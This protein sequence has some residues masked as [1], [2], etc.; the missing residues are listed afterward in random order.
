MGLTSYAGNVI[1]TWLSQLHPWYI[2]LH[3]SN[4]TSDGSVGEL[5]GNGYSRQNISFSVN[6]E[7]QSNNILAIFGPC[8]TINWGLVGWVSIW[9]SFEGGNCYWQGP[10]P[11]PSIINIGDQLRIPIAGLNL[12]FT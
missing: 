1:S 5:V 7:V 8:N 6:S 12:T 11:N 10:S 3:V 4:P 9:D 2:A